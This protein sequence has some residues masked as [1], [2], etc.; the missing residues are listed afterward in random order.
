MAIGAKVFDA[1]GGYSLQCSEL[2]DKAVLDPLEYPPVFQHLQVL[3]FGQ[4]KLI[5]VLFG[6]HHPGTRIGHAHLL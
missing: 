6:A 5:R 1:M 3:G 2:S 4:E